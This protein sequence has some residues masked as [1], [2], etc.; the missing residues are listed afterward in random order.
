VHATQAP[1][2]SQTWSAPQ[3]VPAERLPKSWQ[4]GA[5]VRQLTMPVLHAVGFVEQFAFGVQLPQPPLPS[6]T[7]L[8]P[9]LV[10]PDL[11]TPSTQVC[12]PVAHE[13]TPVLHA[14]GLPVHGC[15]ALHAAQA[16]LPSQ[17]MPT[18]QLV[19]AGV[20]V[21]SVQVVA[22]P[23]QVVLPSL[24]ALGLPVQLWLATHA[25]QKPAPSHIC[26]PVQVAVF[27]LGV[28]SMQVDA[29]VT[30][31][32]V[33]LRQIDGFVVQAWLAVHD[34]QVPVPL[35]TWFVPQVVP[36]A[37]LPLSTHLG[38][39]AA[40][41]I[42]PVLQ[43]EPGLVVQALPASHAT[44]WPLPLQTW[45][46]PHA[47]PAPALSPSTQPDAEPE[48]HATTPSLQGPLGFVVHTV[49]AA[50]F[51]HAPALQTL[52]IPHVVPSGALV[53]SWHCGAPVVHATAPFLHG[54]LGFVVHS[55]PVAHGMQVPAA[56]Q[57]WPVPQ[58]APGLFA[59]LFMQPTGSQT[60][61]PVRH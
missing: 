41:S 20:F 17:T 52:S 25:P 28:P 6:Q 53:S 32:V 51:M 8:V 11:L 14:F 16:P 7:M 30:H 36:A 56:L 50:Q 29:P 45:F 38:A 10:P 3:A 2:P 22:V 44:H 21:P 12:A 61:M 43:G 4:T 33:P 5:P 54:L 26:P 31:E 24:H 46:V 18:P 40:Q 49:P 15:P 59:V 48:P 23:L 55:A 1:L 39:P 35:H 27:G 19:P 58:L 34:T 47:V 60:M 13:V 57:T 37:V 42:T 9:Q